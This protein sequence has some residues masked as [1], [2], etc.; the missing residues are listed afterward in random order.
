MDE[1]GEKNYKDDLER[2]THK[3]HLAE[4]RLQNN[5]DMWN[6]KDVNRFHRQKMK[7]WQK[8]EDDE[9]VAKIKR[10]NE[11]NYR[12]VTPVLKNKLKGLAAPNHQVGI[13][14][15]KYISGGG[16]KRKTKRRKKRKRKKRKTKRKKRKSKNYV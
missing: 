2:L 15:K 6:D 12:L 1:I 13:K 14:I 4:S 3:R 11:S 5:T 9:A 7:L 10:V 8:Q 16:K